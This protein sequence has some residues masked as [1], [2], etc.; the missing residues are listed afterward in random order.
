MKMEILTTLSLLAMQAI[1]GY[2]QKMAMDRPNILFCIADD[3]SF[4]HA[5]AYGCKWVKTPAFDRVAREGILFTNAFTPNAKCSP[6]RSCILTGRT[7]WQ[8]EAAANHVPYFPAKFKTYAETLMEN[9]YHVGHTAKGWAPGDPGMMNGKKRELLGP[10]YNTIKTVPPAKFISDIDYTANFEAFLNDSNQ[11]KPFCFWFGS[12]EPHRPYEFRAGTGKGGKSIAEI[13][14]VYG[15]WPDNDTVRNDLLDYAFEIE[16]F[17]SHIGKML[18]VLENKGL[19][20]NTIVIITADNGMPFPRIKGN[21]YMLSNHLPL[22][23]R[24]PKG[25]SNPGRVVSDFVSFTDFAPTFLEVAGV[26]A[27]LSGMA[28]MEG[29]SLLPLLSAKQKGKFREFMV[30]GKERTD[31]GRPDDLGYPI[32]G[33]VSEEFLYLKNYFPDRWPAGNPETG[34]MDCDGSPTKSYILNERRSR[35]K[36]YFWELNFGKHPGE[37]LYLLT[38]DQECTENLADQPEYA[39]LKAKLVS[40][41]EK[42]LRDDKDPRILGKGEI[43]DTYPYSEE[44]QRN[45]YNRW[46]SGEKMSAGWI[47]QT[48][49]EPP[50]LVK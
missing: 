44:K 31:L 17:D 39:S 21:G 22:A 49:V 13:E 33:I 35:G 8:L 12:T 50:G 45:Y 29:K 46:L 43:F 3:Q 41:M 30:I 36:S 27:S 37:E 15:F 47:E 32:R 9:G 10:A 18:K 34:Y 48:D 14:K 28:E 11:G 2:S 19:L 6:S 20:E 4:P 5:G 23:I 7:S 40:Q 25:I 38:K 1:A 42:K 24:W 16:Y 26:A